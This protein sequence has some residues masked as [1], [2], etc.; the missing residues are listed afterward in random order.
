MGVKLLKGVATRF[1]Y[2]Q[3]GAERWATATTL[4]I[5]I[6]HEM[7]FYPVFFGRIPHQQNLLCRSCLSSYSLIQM[8]TAVL[9][10]IIAC[11]TL[12]EL[13]AQTSLEIYPAPAGLSA[14]KDFEVKIKW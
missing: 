13:A 10:S 7:L 5:D 4:D 6:K 9:S 1:G 2:L 11:L 14:A 12:A 8:K 3:P